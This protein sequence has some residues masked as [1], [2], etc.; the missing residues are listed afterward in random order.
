MAFTDKY[1]SV[2]ENVSNPDAKKT[3]L[4]NDAYAIGLTIEELITKIN[5]LMR[6]LG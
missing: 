1:I 4:S 5:E 2:S 6:R 3:M